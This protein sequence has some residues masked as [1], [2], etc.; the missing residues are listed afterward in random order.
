VYEIVRIDE[1]MR[2]TLLVNIGDI[3]SVRSIRLRPANKV[4]FAV[5]ET[6]PAVRLTG[7]ELDYYLKYCA[8]YIRKELLRKPLALYDVYSTVYWYGLVPLAIKLIVVDINPAPYAYLAEATDVKIVRDVGVALSVKA[9][10]SITDNLKT[11]FESRSK[12]FAS[13]YSQA[14]NV[15]TE[16]Y[17]K[18]R[19]LIPPELRVENRNSKL[20]FINGELRVRIAIG[21]NASRYIPLKDYIAELEKIT[22]EDPNVAYE[23][24]KLLLK[25]VPLILKLT[26][27]KL[28]EENLS[29]DKVL[30]AIKDIL[31]NVDSNQQ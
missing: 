12:E 30:K 11:K 8:N 27:E 20:A 2:E 19:N 14:K 26:I 16:I 5:Y 22:K 1:S 28:E 13:K 9:M 24:V 10:K 25:D 23:E 3:V 21:E 31:I 7:E 15:L 18:T 6:S 4:V 17:E 29:L